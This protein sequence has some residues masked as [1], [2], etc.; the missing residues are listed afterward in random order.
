MTTCTHPKKAWF[1]TTK[2]QKIRFTVPA[3]HDLKYF[4]PLDIPCDKCDKC[5]AANATAWGVRCAMEM[6]MHKQSTFLTLTYDEEHVSHSLVPRHMTLFMKRFRKF[7]D[8]HHP[9]T[10]IRLY[11]CGEYGEKTHRP[12]HHAL[13]FGYDFPDQEF[14]ST[15]SKG[16]KIFSSEILD[17]LWGQGQCKIGKATIASA[18]YIAKYIGKKLYGKTDSDGVLYS[19]G[20]KN[21]DYTR[22]D[23]ETGELQTLHKEYASHSNNMGIGHSFYRKYKHDMFPQGRI[24]FLTTTGK[25]K[26]F[27]VPQYFYKQLAAD[28]PQLF[29]QAKAIRDKRGLDYANEHP[30]ESTPERQRTKALLHK[31]AQIGKGRAFDEQ[32]PKSHFIDM[33]EVDKQLQ[34]REC[35]ELMDCSRIEFESEN[36]TKIQGRY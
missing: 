1:H 2:A 18:I 17:K 21:T 12:H 36:Y 25:M 4:S 3:K 24:P 32:E 28:D 27:P 31:Q 13:I 10:K 6:H 7:V 34:D 15:T 19:G 26:E 20:S 33:S 14:H 16:E 29:L 22:L 5:Q 35:Q 11:Q 23:K 8:K 30:E 9:N